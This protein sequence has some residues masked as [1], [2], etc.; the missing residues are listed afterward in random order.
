MIIL[1]SVYLEKVVPVGPDVGPV[2]LVDEVRLHLGDGQVDFLPIYESNAGAKPERM[3]LTS[4]VVIK[5][6]QTPAS[7]RRESC[8]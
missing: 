1:I 2:L 8:A 4:T 7:S 5:P 6:P 3:E